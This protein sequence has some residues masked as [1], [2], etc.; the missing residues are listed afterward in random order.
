[1]QRQHEI[2]MMKLRMQMQTQMQQSPNPELLH[3]GAQDAAV[4]EHDLLHSRTYDRL[5]LLNI[6]VPYAQLFACSSPS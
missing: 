4:T 1:M 6:V 2:E 3:A 5:Y